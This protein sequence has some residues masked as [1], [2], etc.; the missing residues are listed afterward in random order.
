MF[1]VMLGNENARIPTVANV[2]GLVIVTETVT[3]VSHDV[4]FVFRLVKHD[5]VR[6]RHLYSIAKFS[7]SDAPISTT[8]CG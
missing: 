7:A 1:F 3:Q 8:Y 4:S 6:S 5:G 2:K